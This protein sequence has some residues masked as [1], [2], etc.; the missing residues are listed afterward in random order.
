MARK[1][2]TRKDRTSLVI[3]LVFHGLLIAGVVYW[4]HKSEQLEKIRQVLLQYA[5]EKKKQKKEEPKPI[6]QKAQPPKLP[7]INQGLPQQSSGGS[8]RAVA[9]D[10]PSATGESFFQDTHR[11][12]QGPSTAGSDGAPKPPPAKIVL[13]PPPVIPRP[14]FGPPPASTVKQLLADRAKAAAS[15]E[16]V[17]AEQISKAGASDAGAAVTKVAGAT[18]VEGKFAVI[19]GLSDRYISTTLNGANIPSADPYRQSASLDLFPSQVIEKVVASKTFT[20]DQPG[21]FTG[22]GIDIVTRSFPE[23]AFLSASIG[24]AYNTQS[25]L[26]DH[27]LTYKGGAVDWAGMDDGSRALPDKVNMEA[28]IAPTG[29]ALP[30]AVPGNLPPNSPRLAGNYLLNDLT[31]ELGTTEFAP[32]RDAPPLNQNFSIAGGGTTHLFGRPFGYFGGGSYKHDFSFYEDGISQRIQNGTEVKSRY[33]DAR[34]LGIVNWSGMVNLAYQPFEDHELGFIFFY[35]QNAVDDS[36]VQNNGFEKNSS[37]TFRKFNLYWTQRNLNTYQIK[38]EHRFPE[39]GGLKF[40]W[41]V[42]LTQTT[43][44][45]PDARFFNDNNTG[46]GYESGGNGVPSPSKP[47]RYFRNLEENNLNAKLDWTLP[48]HNW[49]AEDGQ[50][51]FGLFDSSSERTFTERQFYYPG[52]GA[53]H[54]DPN[55]LLTDAT[56]GATIRTNANK[57]VNFNWHQFIQVFDSLYSGDRNVQAAYL[58][59]DVPVVDKMRLVGGARYE[60]TDFNVHSESYLASSVTS[61]KVN[62]AKIVQSDLLPSAGLIY[63]VNPN[64]NIRLN[65]SQT[66]AR[67]SFRELAAYYSYDPVINDF[68]EGNPL[69][70][71]TSIDNYDARW[72]W[73]PRPG[74]L[75]SV[76][77]FY[78]ALENAIERG[79]LKVEGDV[80]TFLNREKAK[81]YGIE[82][83]ARKNL[84][85]LGASFKPFS[86]GGNLS[87]IQSE[88]H[89]TENEVFNK[90]QFFPDVKTT[91]PLYDQSPYVVNLD[92]NYD[93]PYAGTSAAFIFSI[94]GPRIAITKLNADDVYEQPAPVLDFVVSQKIGRNTTVKLFAKNLLDPRIERTYGKDSELLYDSYK[95]GRTFGVTLSYNF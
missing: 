15:I 4:A 10:A 55:Q 16:A 30:P 12:V 6:Q 88:V 3:S 51:K 92:L 53:Y 66:I 62:D 85:F 19:R 76:S 20:P 78:K 87:L 18:I 8:R 69:L 32:K 82:F 94:A 25:S 37:G 95:R 63:T 68:I 26:N 14:A 60:T 73:F 46:N 56:L 22:G 65:Y 2:R 81:L 23:N 39:V 45:E 54:D 64:M 61:Q 48:F 38:G 89:L 90:S 57:T 70:K 5:G 21:A 74:E 1:T 42:A 59:L 43:Q 52:G 91:R 27:F 7:P 67:P 9:V 13:P 75:V 11:Q 41:L 77:V 44:D 83:E 80:I 33:S 71:M 93:N 50:F 86:V 47:T 72:E 40:D 35:N 36:R 49:T 84:D 34:S 31:H 17:G 24:T 58:M 79:D 28:P 29:Q